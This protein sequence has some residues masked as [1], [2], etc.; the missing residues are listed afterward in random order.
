VRVKVVSTGHLEI[1][2]VPFLL[3]TFQ[4][5]RLT[6]ESILGQMT[7][8]PDGQASPRGNSCEAGERAGIN[9]HGKRPAVSLPQMGKVP[10]ADG[11]M[12]ACPA[13]PI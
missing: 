10:K 8:S 7:Q 1:I 2:R 4:E 6:D 13:L 11:M 12:D 5:M 3:E 9:S